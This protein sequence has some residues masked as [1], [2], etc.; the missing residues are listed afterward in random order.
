MPAESLLPLPPFLEGK[1]FRL[2]G[3]L[4]NKIVKE[5]SQV[6]TQLEHALWDETGVQFS[7]DGTEVGLLCS[8]GWPPLWLD[9]GLHPDQG[10][11]PY[12]NPYYQKAAAPL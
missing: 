8:R 3:Y 12:P 6:L 7:L 10:F 11:P 2:W 9:G 1:G 4:T 5:E